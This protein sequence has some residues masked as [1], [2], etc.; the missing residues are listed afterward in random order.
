MMASAAKFPL[1]VVAGALLAGALGF[2]A[3]VV[4]GIEGWWFWGIC[5]GSIG[6]ALASYADEKDEVRH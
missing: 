6:G 1:R 4:F 2:A 5:A 3:D